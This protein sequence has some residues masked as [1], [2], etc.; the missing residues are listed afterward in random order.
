MSYSKLIQTLE[1][2]WGH[3]QD[4]NPELPDCLILAAT[5]GRSATKL[6]GHFCAN[7]WSVEGKDLHEVLIVAEQLNR[8]AKDIFQTLY[9]ESIHAICN[10]RGVKDVSG[11]RHNK[12]FVQ[13]AEEFGMIRPDVNDKYLGFSAVTLA[14][15]TEERYAGLIAAISEAT[16]L[17]RKL[18][19]K[20]KD[21]PVTS[22]SAVCE[23][24]RKIR[25]G[26]KFLNEQD[27][28]DAKLELVCSLCGTEFKID[29]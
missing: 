16:I 8:P 27:P 25:V 28:D 11:K 1:E 18:K 19:L 24:E 21:T 7:S 10:K 4:G 20:D 26:K 17:C 6:Y 23:C 5:G 9:H 13:V 12:R 15:E 29:S 22:W 2:C 3:L 14:P